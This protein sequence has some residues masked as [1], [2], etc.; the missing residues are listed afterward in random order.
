MNPSPAEHSRRGLLYVAVAVFFFSTSPVF[1][2]WADT[3]TS[4][5]ITF[6]RLLIAALGVAAVMFIRRERWAIPRAER[7]RFLL[8]GLVTALHFLFYIASLSFTT[9]AHSLAI[10]YTAPIFV[11]LFSS[12]FLGE[13]IARRKWLGIALAVV[14]VAIL[15]GF[16]PQF[17]RRMLIGD[18]LALGS[19]ITFGLYS[20]AGRSQRHR[21]SLFTYAATVYGAAALWA[22]APAWFSFTPGGYTPRTVLS[23]IGLGLIPLGLGHT[24]YNAALRRTHATYVN[25]IATQ[26]VTGGILLGILLLGEIPGLNEVIGAAVTLLGVLLVIL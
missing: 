23:L 5:E 9:I 2:R 8:F 12:L 20:V 15:A 17:D 26:E 14:G 19:A 7:G 22:A 6:W 18:A 11:T 24:L 21:Y 1:V 25:V 13:P 16:Q 4:Y 10:V 3:I